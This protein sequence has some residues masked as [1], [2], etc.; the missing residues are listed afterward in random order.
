VVK[1]YCSLAVHCSTSLRSFDGSH[2]TGLVL[3]IR[4]TAAHTEKRIT[5]RLVPSLYRIGETHGDDFSLLLSYSL[6]VS[7]ITK[8][9]IKGVKPY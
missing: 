3:Y 6:L 1:P 2:S 7:Y 5:M 8:S 9:Q 4:C